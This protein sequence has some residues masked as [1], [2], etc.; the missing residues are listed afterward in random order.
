MKYFPPFRFEERTGVLLRAGSPVHLSRKAAELLECLLVSPGAVV[1]HE[2]IMQTVWPDTHVQPENVKTVIHELRNAL[3]DHSHAP[4]FICSEPGRGYRFRADVTVGMPPLFSDDESVAESQF[5]GRGGELDILRRHVEATSDKCEPQLVLIEGDRGVGKTTLCDVFAHRVR[6]REG[7]RTS[8]AT[9]AEVWGPMERHAVLTDAFGLLA[10][11]Y[12]HVVPAAF[13]R[14]ASGWLAKFPDWPE[15]RAQDADHNSHDERLVRELIAVLDELTIDVPLLLI[16]E[17]LQWADAATVDSLRSIARGQ[18]PGRVCI[19]ATFCASTRPPT[20]EYLD[21]LAREFRSARGCSVIRLAPFTEHE[22]FQCL[23]KRWGPRVSEA[24]AKPLFLA[25]GGNPR[26][27]V[28]TMDS[29]ARMGALHVTHDGWQLA[30][31][32]DRLEAVLQMGLADGL[33]SQIDQLTPDEYCILEAAATVGGEF[34]AETVAGSLGVSPSTV[35]NRRLSSLAERRLLVELIDD[36][37][38]RLGTGRKVFK[39]R[40]QV[41]SDLLLDRVPLKCRMPVEPA[42]SRRAAAPRRA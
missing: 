8:L 41:T 16:L 7:F 29:L 34:T 9:G 23:E 31:P 38:R 4:Q 32:P 26:L 14:R 11:Q 28:M 22:L 27:A 6:R 42:E 30:T 5:V 2:R 15:A 37:G 40:H 20:V 33:Q 12:P 17:D 25:G 10:R 24:V 13:A 18:F 36:G 19:L 39:F 21:R 1:S 35:I 3:G